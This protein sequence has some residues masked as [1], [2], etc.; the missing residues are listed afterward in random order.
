MNRGTADSVPFNSPA[1]LTTNRKPFESNASCSGPA[2][3]LRHPPI[4]AFAGE[5]GSVVNGLIASTGLLLMGSTLLRPGVNSDLSYSVIVPKLAPG[6]GT[7]QT[8]VVAQA[9]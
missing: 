6:V 7:P 8:V 5:Y 4:V 3:R 2:R 9:A 1:L